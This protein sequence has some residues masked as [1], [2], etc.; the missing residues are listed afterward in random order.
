MY[1]LME[2]YKKFPEMQKQRK[3]YVR[4][5]KIIKHNIVFMWFDNLPIFTELE[6]FHYSKKKIQDAATIFSLKTT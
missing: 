1:K 6:E 3:M 2:I 4:Q 5:R